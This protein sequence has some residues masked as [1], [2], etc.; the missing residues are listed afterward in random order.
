MQILCNTYVESAVVCG[1]N[2]VVIT[3]TITILFR[4][5]RW[6]QYW[7]I[8]RISVFDISTSYGVLFDKYTKVHGVILS[9]QNLDFSALPENFIDRVQKSSSWVKHPA[10]FF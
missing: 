10:T 2:L 3:I 8:L 4:F 7:F 9:A 1:R 5:D 6:V